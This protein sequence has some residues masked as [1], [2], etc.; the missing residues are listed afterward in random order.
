MLSL[1]EEL[2]TGLCTELAPNKDD[3][4]WW[5]F[6]LSITDR[7]NPAGFPE[8]QKTGFFVIAEFYKKVLPEKASFD[9]SQVC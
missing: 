1:P 3:S 5:F 4:C 6:G 2:R 9:S 8:R 7:P